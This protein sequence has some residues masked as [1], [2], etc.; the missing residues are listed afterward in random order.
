[1]ECGLTSRVLRPTILIV[2][3]ASQIPATAYWPALTLYE[4]TLEKLCF[5]GDH[6]QLAPYGSNDVK[7]LESIFE[8]KH[9]VKAAYF[10]DTQ[11]RMPHPIGQ[12]ISANVYESKLKTVHPIESLN[13]LRLVDVQG[14][15]TPGGHSTK[16]E[17]EARCCI[18]IARQVTGKDWRILT[19]YDAQRQ[20]IED[21]LKAEN[22]PWEDRVFNV[23]SFQG[24]EADYIIVSL[25]RTKFPGFLRD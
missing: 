20:L 6:K 13:S 22:L 12:F 5:V 7:S 23:D 17:R 15:E 19:A 24:N 21:M 3:E 4:K 16:N 1:R 25:V 8:Q 18:K 14:G 2:D 10:L 9:L 11:Y